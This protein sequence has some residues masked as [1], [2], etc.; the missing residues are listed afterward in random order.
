[1]ARHCDLAPLVK[2]Y[3]FVSVNV[4]APGAR[5]AVEAGDPLVQYH[6]EML[7]LY[8]RTGGCSSRIAQQE[9]PLGDHP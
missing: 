6:R 8:G 4:L 1:M 3:A 7:L 5:K 9:T 2:R